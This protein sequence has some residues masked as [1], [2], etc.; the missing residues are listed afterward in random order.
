MVEQNDNIRVARQ[1]VYQPIK[2]KLRPR[3]QAEFR[4]DNRSSYQR[5]EDQKKADYK[6]K[7]YE[8]AKQDA[9]A[10]EGFENLMNLLAPST[11]V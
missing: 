1:P 11:Y 8:K 5:R 4:P 2:R 10:Q 7:Q 6:H 3:Q 9:K